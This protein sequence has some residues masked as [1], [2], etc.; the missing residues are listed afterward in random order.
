MC[1]HTHTH[2]FTPTVPSRRGACIY[3]SVYKATLNF[4]LTNPSYTWKIIAR[5]LAFILFGL[6]HM[7]EM[8]SLLRPIMFL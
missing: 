7:W 8:K 3:V 1:L 4:C 2:T 5:H 6:Q